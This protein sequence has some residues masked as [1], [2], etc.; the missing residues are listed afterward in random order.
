MAIAAH[1]EELTASAAARDQRRHL[2]LEAQGAVAGRGAEAVL[3]HNVSTSG[4]LLETS[5][6]LSVDERIVIDLPEAPGTPARVIWTSG[7][8]AGCQFDAPI[9]AAALSAAQLQGFAPEAGVGEFGSGAIAGG[10]ALAVRLQRLRKARG[11]SMAQVAAQL[12]VSKPTVW[13][14]E[15]GKARPVETRLEALAQA[16]GVSREELMPGPQTPALRE[17]L[18][19]TRAQIAAALGTTPDRIRI[20]VDL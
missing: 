2:L 11:L 4:L 5:T 9:P 19:R 16:L 13:A 3:I 17:L 14:W 8:L 20:M 1:F 7:A 10:E 12:G 6:A 18:N 15:Q